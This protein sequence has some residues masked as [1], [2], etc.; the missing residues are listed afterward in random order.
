MKRIKLRIY[1][2]GKVQAQTDG[3][4]GKACL[5]Y[6]SIIEGLTGVRTV[7]SEFTAEYRETDELLVQQNDVEVRA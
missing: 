7:D 5:D 3:I 6:I 4:K 2:N 1:P